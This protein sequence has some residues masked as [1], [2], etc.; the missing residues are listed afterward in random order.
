MLEQQVIC[1][2]RKQSQ[3]PRVTGFFYLYFLGIMN[4]S[5]TLATLDGETLA[6]QDHSQTN[7]QTA[8][9]GQ[10][11]L[12]HGLGEHMGRYGHVIQHLNDWGFAVRSYDHFG[13]GQSSGAHGCLPS[14]NRLLDDLALVVDDTRQHMAAQGNRNVPLILVGHSMGGLVAAQFVAQIIRPVDALILSSPALATSLPS[15][16]NTA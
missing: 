1:G 15:G 5:S 3:S 13:R 9:R 6:L 4:T 10:I 8:I 11:L 2:L 14:E 16:L 12:V 7:S